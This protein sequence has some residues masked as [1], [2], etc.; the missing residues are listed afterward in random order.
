MLFTPSPCHKL[1]HLLGPPPTLERD[2]LYGRPL[3]HLILPA[4][5]SSPTV[6]VNSTHI[7]HSPSF[8]Q[9]PSDSENTL[10]SAA[11]ITCS[12]FNPRR[13]RL[14]NGSTL[15]F[16]STETDLVIRTTITNRFEQN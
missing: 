4:F 3:R 15:G 1:S 11:I 8:S 16:K 13:R 5:S 9:L 14:L 10:A 6:A 7:P 12:V 2:V